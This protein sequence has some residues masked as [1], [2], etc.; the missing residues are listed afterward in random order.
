M[1]MH[2]ILQT[3]ADAIR[4]QLRAEENQWVNAVLAF[5]VGLVMVFDGEFVFKWLVVGFTFVISLLIALNDVSIL[6]GL[7]AGDPLRMVIG[8]EAGAA[9]AFA[10]YKGIDGMMMV[11]AFFFGGFVAFGLQNSLAAFINVSDNEA[12]IVGLY[13]VIVAGTM[14]LVYFKKHARMLIMVSSIAG[15]LFVSTAL[16]YFIALA[17]VHG[18]MHWFNHL[19]P[20]LQPAHLGCWVDYVALL[21]HGG[22]KDVGV[23][24]GEDVHGIPADRIAGC[25]LWLLVSFF[26]IYFQVNSLAARQA[27]TSK[28]GKAA[29]GKQKKVGTA[30]VADGL[31]APLIQGS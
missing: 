18:L 22:R 8:V 1:T 16:S 30:V 15:G 2:S 23:L 28:R 21:L 3:I 31:Q 9:M 10:A 6:W 20:S 19:F 13:S 7:G 11:I 27:K 12:L 4:R 29:P 17:S 25:T 24:I 14:T 5:V 26:G